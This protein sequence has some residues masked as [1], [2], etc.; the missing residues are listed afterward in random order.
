MF[1]AAL[2]LAVL[3]GFSLIMVVL[4]AYFF[5]HSESV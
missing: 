2:N 1:S 3:A 4:G 5:E